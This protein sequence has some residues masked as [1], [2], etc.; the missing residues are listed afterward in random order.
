[1][2]I[3]FLLPLFSF[4]LGLGVG[5]FINVVI[6]RGARDE[7][8]GG[9]SRC[10]SCQT[11]LSPTELIP[12][13]SF[14]AQKGRCRT[15]RTP[16]SWQYPLVELTTAA[17]Y[18]GAAWY[19]VS[20]GLEFIHILA[21]FLIFVGVGAALVIAISDF[22]FTIIPNGPVVIL[23]L[24]GFLAAGWRAL[25]SPYAF[26]WGP[27]ALDLASSL[28]LA[29]IL[30]SLWFFSGGKWMGLGDGKLIFA[31]SLLTGYPLNIGAFVLSFWAGSLV[32]IFLV[33]IRLKTWRQAMPF[34]PYILL[35]MASAY[36]LRNQ[37]FSLWN[38]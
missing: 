13:I 19:T 3:N 5:S 15:C 26:N 20:I 1:M 32:G 17:L 9:R 36:L 7:R 29:L 30:A 11:V 10:E 22:R 28:G 18:G 34:G 33:L 27:A 37:I 14:F 16:I 8:L 24:L 6:I 4:V 21:L 12:L 31:T 23:L 2:E 38:F 35:G 25:D